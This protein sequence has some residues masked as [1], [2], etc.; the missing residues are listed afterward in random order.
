MVFEETTPDLGGHCTNRFLQQ[1]VPNS[2]IRFILNLTSKIQTFKQKPETLKTELRI[3]YEV[4]L[5]FCA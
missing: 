5:L 4:L 3:S 1:I 2:V